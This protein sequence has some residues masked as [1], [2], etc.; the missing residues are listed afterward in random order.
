MM[1][2]QV[3][4]FRKGSIEIVSGEGTHDFPYHTHESMMIGVIVRGS[5]RFA[6]DQYEYEL[7][8]GMTYLV[9]PDTG[10]SL[11]HIEP[12]QYITICIMRDLL[13]PYNLEVADTYVLEGLG[14]DILLLCDLF[15]SGLLCQEEFIDKLA[16]MLSLQERRK[17]ARMIRR[18]A[19]IYAALEYIRDHVNDKFN[20]D[21]LSEAVH[22]TKFHLVRSFKKNMGVGPKQYHQQ[23]KIRQ[24]KYKLLREETKA[25]IAADLSFAHQSH[26]CSV[27]RKYMGISMKDYIQNTVISKQ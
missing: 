19:N 4:F 6:V 16:D 21:D 9:P 12:Y 25:G 23:C 13:L 8:Q 15:C 3:Q 5:V 10:S 26:L 1:K 20:L 22:L 18:D 27:F 14:R 24:A 2:N 11:T 17:E 7:S